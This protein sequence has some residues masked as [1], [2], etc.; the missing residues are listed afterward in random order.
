MTASVSAAAP[1]IQALVDQIN[2]RY[3]RGQPAA[4][5]ALFWEHPKGSL[6]LVET[7]TA[8]TPLQALMDGDFERVERT[9]HGHSER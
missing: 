8:R 1:E 2:E 9:V 5:R 4:T 7:G 6:A 3:F